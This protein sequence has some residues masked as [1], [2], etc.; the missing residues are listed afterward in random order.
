MRLHRSEIWKCYKVYFPTIMKNIVV[1][2][3]LVQI[4]LYFMY[5]LFKD[6]I[7]LSFDSFINNTH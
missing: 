4:K 1:K 5:S 7:L 6:Q 3:S 2:L